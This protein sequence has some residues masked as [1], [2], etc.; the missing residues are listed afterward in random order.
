MGERCVCE[1]PSGDVFVGM[2]GVVGVRSRVTGVPSLEKCY[3]CDRYATAAEA[4]A[5]YHA[6]P[7]SLFG[8]VPVTP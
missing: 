8:L 5:A 1:E 3:G 6:G 7:V 2:P 4:A